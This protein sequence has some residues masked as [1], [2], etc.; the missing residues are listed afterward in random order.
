MKQCNTCNKT[1]Q[2][3][4]F[5]SNGT[6]IR[7]I[8]RNCRLEQVRSNRNAKKQLEKVSITEKQCS[9]CNITK[10]I[11]NFNKLSL[12]PDGYFSKCRDCVKLLRIKSTKQPVSDIQLLCKVCNNTKSST[13]FRQTTRS[14]TGYY[15]TCNECWKPVEWSKEKQKMSEKKY[16]EANRDKIKA[17]W[18]KAGE[19]INRRVR[20]RLNHRIADALRAQ[21]NRKSNKTVNYIGCEISY[22]KKWLE[23]QFTEE[24][25]WHNYGQWHIDHVVPCSSFNLENQDEQY[26]CFNWKNLRP[27]LAKENM[28]KGQKIIEEIIAA[29]NKT[30]SNFLLVN[31]LPTLPGDR[32]EGTE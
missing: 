26:K 3:D 22:L 12:S 13:S 28:E 4:A 15:R 7:N 1:L 30:V 14:S 6:Y 2:L 10:T 25:G 21:Q 24:I 9:N 5:E 19:N 23:Y 31:P 29:H 11:D 20:D 17:K 18:Q 8:C 27:C 16:V 32:V